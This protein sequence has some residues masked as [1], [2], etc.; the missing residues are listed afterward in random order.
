LLGSTSPQTIAGTW[1]PSSIVTGFITA[2]AAAASRLPIGIDPVKV[3]FAT[4][5]AAISR[6]E[7][8]SSSPK[9]S[10]TAAG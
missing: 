7:T 6:L 9:T 10:A 1:P 4:A 3:I 2:P 5:G 8:R